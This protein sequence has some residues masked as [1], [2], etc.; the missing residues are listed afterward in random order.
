MTTPATT[1]ADTPEAAHTIEHHFLTKG[2]GIR[3]SFSDTYSLE[4]SDGGQWAMQILKTSN[5][6]LFYSPHGHATAAAAY[7]TFMQI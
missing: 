6:P 4:D 3:S 5:T 7:S 2:K 1:Y